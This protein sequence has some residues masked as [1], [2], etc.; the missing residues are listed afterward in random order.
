M[1]NPKVSSWAAAWLLGPGVLLVMLTVMGAV[2]LIRLMPQLAGLIW[3]REVLA[4]VL[5]LAVSASGLL[6][7]RHKVRSQAAELADFKGKQAVVIDSLQEG[8]MLVNAHGHICNANPACTRLLGLQ[9]NEISGRTVVDP[10]W[11]AI[12]EDGSH[13]PPSD[14]PAMRTLRSGRAEHGVVMG[15]RKPD[16]SVSWLSVSTSPA[17]DE[18]VVVTL[19]DIT[20]RRAAERRQRELEGRFRLLVDSVSDYV[21]YMLDV[22]GKVSSWNSGAERFK[23]YRADEIIG[24]HFSVFYRPEDIAAGKP[25]AELRVAA[26]T[27]RYEE[28]GWRLRKDG[29]CFWA[30]VTVSAIRDEQGELLG[31][32]KVS[33]DLSERR[34]SEQAVAEANRL[35]EAILDASPFAIIATDANGLISAINPA[36]ERMLWYT[37]DDLVNKA[38]PAL[39]HDPEE[40]RLRAIELSAEVGEVIAPGF[41][42]FV[43]PARRGVLDERDWTYIRK[44]GSR[45]P[46][47][48]AVTALRDTVGEISGF[49]GI[50]Y[51]IT[52]RKRREE[53]TRHVAHH[54][55]LTGL[56]NRGLLTDRLQLALLQARRNGKSVGLLMLDL[57]HFKRVNDS[58]GHHVGDQL[59]VTVAERLLSCVRGA[60]TVARMGGDEFVVVLPEIGDGASAERL[61]HTILDTV[62]RPVL[63]GSHE[64]QV[65]PS[66]GISLYPRDGAD[67]NALLRNADT[68]MYRAKGS[69]RCAVRL[70]NAE[71]ERA[72]AEK[73][74]IENA[75]H[76]ALRDH[77]FSLHYQPQVS[78]QTGQVTGMEALLRWPESP[79]RLISPDRFIPVAEESGLIVPIGD[80][81]L[82]TACR[83]GLELQKRSGL[84]LQIAV[85]ISSRQFRR[86]EFVGELAA[87]LLETGLAP[88]CLELEI[89][90]SLLMEQTEQSIER[91]HQIRALGVGVAI[92]DFGVG[93][94]SL[95][96]ITR[97]PISTLKID[98]S[99]VSQMPVSN[100]DAAVAKAIIALAASLQIRVVAEGVETTAQLE[101]LR[102]HDC[103]DAQGNYFGPAVPAEQLSVQGFHFS[104]A[105]P[106]EQFTETISVLQGRTLALLH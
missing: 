47:N 105:V 5:L 18:G 78:L 32:A 58:L 28:E 50:A 75:L 31:Y 12:R 88:E 91:L 79:S 83:Q 87:I 27:G 46:V 7:L 40:V 3:L 25:D 74:A 60:D 69:G 29:S 98:R 54:D 76:R 8:L 24:R 33:R 41:E 102:Q 43:N 95:S 72:A 35:R 65:T 62:S 30:H 81:V 63:V 37:R 11:I 13:W 101:F 10:Y 73:L 20:A 71:M 45:F 56:P 19:E 57:D 94:S 103:R 92:D 68:A 70:F 48:L 21:I 52:E 16:H 80:W 44:D 14:F 9:R 38:T 104:T 23:G 64:L 42:V 2:E 39:I 1:N 6:F 93:F 55:H 90:E 89:T 85:N 84:P 26:I 77:E 53:Y 22:S 67:A 106:F 49:L 36:A 17:G 96:Y 66:I 99:F 59:L 15:I 4:W 100:S 51:D 82:R 61:A 97:F 34:Q 86:A